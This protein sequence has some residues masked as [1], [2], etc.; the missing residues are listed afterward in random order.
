MLINRE[1]WQNQLRLSKNVKGSK[2]MH[3]VSI[4]VPVYNVEK[5]L[6]KC[7]ESILSQTYRD[8]EVLLIDDGSTDGSA[9]ICKEYSRQDDRIRYIRQENGG[10]GNARNRGIQ[11]A[12]GKYILFIDSDDYIAENMVEQ[13][14]QNIITSGADMATCGIY[15]VFQQKCTAQYDKIEKFLCSSEEAFGLLLIG[16][17]IPGSSCNKL[18]QADILKDIRF[19]EGI[20]Y[21]DVG[22]HIDLMQ[23]VE[24]VYVDTTPL[25]YYVH[26]ENSITTKKFDSDAMMFIYAY[27]ETLKVVMEKYPAIIEEARFKLFWAYFAILDRILKEEQYWK[28]SEYKKVKHYLKRNAVRIIRNPYFH[29]ARKI[30]AFALLVNI[31]L[32]RFMI[33]MNDKNNK[34]II[35]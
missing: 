32:Y 3:S 34:S 28:I 20:P 13:L 15:N 1:T 31:R 19:P 5:Y 12:S 9:D 8:I 7:I 6:A 18:I 35:S 27:N 21:E 4:I 24:T 22:F 10:L 33:M 29:K 25:Y 2:I 14:Y 11:E 26:R 17:K 23:K 30:G 16:E